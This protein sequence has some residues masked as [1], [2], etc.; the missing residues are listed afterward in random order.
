M[1]VSN[2]SVVSPLQFET[3]TQKVRLTVAE[4]KSASVTLDTHMDT[5]H[6]QQTLKI[7]AGVLT[8]CGPLKELVLLQSFA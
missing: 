4:S 6:E 5:T 3:E 7:K 8:R 2:V 1:G